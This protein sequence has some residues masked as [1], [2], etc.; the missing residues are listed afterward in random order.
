MTKTTIGPLERSGLSLIHQHTFGER[1]YLLEPMYW[2]KLMFSCSTLD[3]GWPKI[4]YGQWVRCLD[5]L[6]GLEYVF[7]FINMGKFRSEACIVRLANK[8]VNV[9]RRT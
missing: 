8:L 1:C 7:N 9:L 4:V 3:S 6:N 5:S 2:Q